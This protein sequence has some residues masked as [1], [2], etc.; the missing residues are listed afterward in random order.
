MTEDHLGV[1][2]ELL[3]VIT[4]STNVLLSDQLFLLNVSFLIST[5]LLIIGSITK[6]GYIIYEWPLDAKIFP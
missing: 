1:D 2:A 4:A 5:F 6:E 3:P